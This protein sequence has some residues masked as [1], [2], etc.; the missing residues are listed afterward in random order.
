MKMLFG[1]GLCFIFISDY[2]HR[3]GALIGIGKFSETTRVQPPESGILERNT[4]DRRH[5]IDD[6][7][8]GDESRAEFA[9]PSSRT[10][11]TASLREKYG[12]K[13]LGQQPRAEKG[14]EKFVSVGAAID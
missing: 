3:T 8:V 4:L 2:G 10:D 11:H 9:L 6:R 7:S 5:R 13:F 12:L 14:A 1:V